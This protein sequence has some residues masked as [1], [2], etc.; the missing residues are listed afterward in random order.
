MGFKDDV[1]NVLTGGLPTLL[2]VPDAAPA[3]V[4]VEKTAPEPTNRDTEAFAFPP[5]SQNQILLGGAALFGI[6]ALVFV[7]RN[8]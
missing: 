1:L 3:S 8:R 6:L 5:I 7:M 4:T 2:E